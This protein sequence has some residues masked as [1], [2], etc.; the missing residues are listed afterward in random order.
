M[1]GETFYTITCAQI[2]VRSRTFIVEFRENKDENLFVVKRQEESNSRIKSI[3]TAQKIDP[4]LP[5]LETTIPTTAVYDILTTLNK[6]TLPIVPTITGGFDGY[7]RYL[8]IRNLE[9]VACFS[10]WLDPP[11]G[12]ESL[13]SAWEDLIRLTVI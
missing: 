12:W 9:S 5:F 11:P 10:W 2:G 8:I 6:T 13:N 1:I 7:T 4:K 3:H